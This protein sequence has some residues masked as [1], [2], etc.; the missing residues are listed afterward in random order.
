[1]YINHV[2]DC[3]ANYHIEDEVVIENIDLLATNGE[4]SFGNG[5]EVAVI[6]EA[7]GRE[8]P[9]YDHL[10]AQVAYI[11]ALYRHRPKVVEKLKKMIADC[12]ASVVSSMGFVAKAARITNCRVVKNVRVGPGSVIEAA[13]RLE[14]GS[15]NSC[16]EDPVYIGPA[17]SAEDFIVC[18]GSKITDAAVI[19]RCFIGQGCVVARQFSAENSVFFAN[20]ECLHGEACSIFAGPYTVTHHKSTLLIAGIFSFFNAGSGS[21][22]S[23]HLYKLGPVHQGVLERG[24]KTASDSYMLWPAKVGAFSVVVGK[25][26]GRPD[27]SDFPFSYLGERN[28]ETI[29]APGTNLRKV[30]LVRDERK[31]PRRDRRKDPKKLD[32]INFELLSPYTVQKVLNGCRLLTEHKAAAGGKTDFLGCPGVRVESSAIAN[33]IRVYQNAVDKFLG[34]CL[35]ERLEKVAK[36][37]F[38]NINEL[39]SALKPKTDM[40]IGKWVDLAGLFAPQKYVDKILSDIENGSIGN[41]EQLT[42][43]FRSAYNDYADYR[44]AWAARVLA[45]QIGR[46]INDITVDDIIELV[47]KWK[48]AGEKLA[49][50]NLADAQKEYSGAMRTGYGIDGDEQTRD[51]DFEG[52]RGRFETNSFVCEIKESTDQ[53]TSRA[54]GLISRLEDLR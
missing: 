20:C 24:S 21:N 34:D 29:L 37:V 4:S 38:R 10:S 47:R 19:S 3:I 8:I 1:M 23:N 45:Q 46:D 6:N 42:E 52:V 54:E 11:I 31:W 5:T 16:P 26:Y 15:V 32:L 53:S 13:D 22:Q 35:I 25:H 49:S 7:G 18:S 41:L 30:G 36:N 39:R 12:T 50:W 33:G 43:V 51:A 14:N 44:W 40:G 17:V 28:G 27:T 2:R 9:I 48:K